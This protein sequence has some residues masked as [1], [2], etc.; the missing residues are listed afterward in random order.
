VLKRLEESGDVARKDDAAS[1][2]F[3]YQF[4]GRRMI[5]SYVPPAAK[6]P[7]QPTKRPRS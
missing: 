7:S 5:A 4:V 1:L 3:T 2:R 6:K